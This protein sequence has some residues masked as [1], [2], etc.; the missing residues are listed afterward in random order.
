M[1]QASPSSAERKLRFEMETCSG[2]SVELRP[3]GKNDKDLLFL[4]EGSLHFRRCSVQLRGLIFSISSHLVRASSCAKDCPVISRLLRI[5]CSAE[6]WEEASRAEMG[7]QK[8]NVNRIQAF[9]MFPPHG[10][11]MHMDM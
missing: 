6:S 5:C 8:K 10:H 9:R 1:C 2:A 7:R 11:A 3:W 4:T